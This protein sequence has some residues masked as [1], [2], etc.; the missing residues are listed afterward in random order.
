MF[1]SE[2][3]IEPVRGE[4]PVTVARGTTRPATRPAADE[5]PI[6]EM[7]P[8]ELASAARRQRCTA[9]PDPIGAAPEARR[10]FFRRRPV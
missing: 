2:N 1:G 6:R 3:S 4:M 10:G 7:T 8:T 5:P 9:E